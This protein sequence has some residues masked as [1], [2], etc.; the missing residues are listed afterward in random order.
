MSPRGS[1]DGNK[2]QILRVAL[3]ERATRCYFSM[4]EKLRGQNAFLKI[5]PSHFV[6]FL[7]TDFF[8]TYFEKDIDVLVAQFFDSQ[9]YHDKQMK[10]AGQGEFER[11][12]SD[13]LA[14]IKQVK[15]KARKKPTKKKAARN[16]TD[17]LS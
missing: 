8:E 13:T 7:V 5:H 16:E 12:I 17:S 3:D 2:K 6:S 4:V 14:H 11:V 15:S 10:L 9:G 1:L